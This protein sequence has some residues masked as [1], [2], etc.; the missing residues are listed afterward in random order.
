M[1]GKHLA[2]HGSQV[3]LGDAKEN[4]NN[5]L[6]G[7]TAGRKDKAAFPMPQEGFGLMGMG[8]FGRR[9]HLGRWVMHS[10]GP[11]VFLHGPLQV[12]AHHH[13]EV[14]FFSTVVWD[15]NLFCFWIP[16]NATFAC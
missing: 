5:G 13:G 15:F 14:S 2:K 9:T 8:L 4:P 1:R 10:A 7:T 16:D 12:P 6:G 3:L 11:K